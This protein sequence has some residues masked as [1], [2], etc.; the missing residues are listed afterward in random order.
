MLTT[1]RVRDS[2]YTIYGS[3]K[4]RGKHVTQSSELH[5]THAFMQPKRVVIKFDK[6]LSVI[7]QRCE[8]QVYF[9]LT[10]KEQLTLRLLTNNRLTDTYLLTIDNRH[11][12]PMMYLSGASS[13]NHYRAVCPPRLSVQDKTRAV[14]TV[15]DNKHKIFFLTW[16]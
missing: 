7:V 14:W 6:L 8:K 13:I 1:W 16:L 4:W 9:K 11:S 12:V 2:R 5:A 10:N 3:V 15:N